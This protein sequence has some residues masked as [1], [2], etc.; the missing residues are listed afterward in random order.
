MVNVTGTA[1]APSGAAPTADENRENKTTIE[2]LRLIALRNG[3]FENMCPF[4]PKFD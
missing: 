3:F 1:G 4:L 2:R